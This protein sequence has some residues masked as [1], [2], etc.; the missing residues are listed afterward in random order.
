[1]P[2]TE[3]ILVYQRADENHPPSGET[4]VQVG[5]SMELFFDL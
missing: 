3:T 2:D 1:M 4:L 5:K